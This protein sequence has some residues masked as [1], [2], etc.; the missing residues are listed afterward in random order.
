MVEEIKITQSEDGL[1][2]GEERKGSIGTRL[3]DDINNR[4]EENIRESVMSKPFISENDPSRVDKDS[5]TNIHITR[6]SHRTF[7]LSKLGR[8]GMAK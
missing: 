7:N 4:Y 3:G 1:M 5:S 6:D 2:P 8:Q